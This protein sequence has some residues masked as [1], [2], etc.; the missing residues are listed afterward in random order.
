MYFSAL[1]ILKSILTLQTTDD[2]SDDESDEGSPHL[3]H[4]VLLGLCTLH[5]G[6]GRSHA[7]GQGQGHRGGDHADHGVHDGDHS[8]ES[9]RSRYVHGYDDH[10]DD[11][12]DERRPPEQLLHVIARLRRGLDE[13]HV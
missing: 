1:W 5:A 8:Q 7:S 2:E 4:I 11:H 10:D 3:R 6:Q 13:H 9:C 12:D